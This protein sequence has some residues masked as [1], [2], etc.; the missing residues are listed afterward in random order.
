MYKFL[1]FVQFLFVTSFCY[2]QQIYQITASQAADLAIRNAKDLKNLE[3][4]VEIQKMNNLEVLSAV[5]PQIAASGQATYYTNLPLIQFPTSN[6]AVYQVLEKE[7]VRDGTGNPIDISKASFGVQPV[8]FFAPFNTQLGLNAQQLL[9][10]PDVFIAVTARQT[11]L[12]YAQNNVDVARFKAREQVMKSYYAVLIGKKQQEVLSSS[13]QRLNALLREMKAMYDKGFTEKLDV[14]RIQVSINNTEAALNQLENGLLISESLLKNTM[15]L[16]QKDSLVL[17]ETMDIARLQEVLLMSDTSFDYL[18]RPEVRLLET[19]KKLQDIELNRYRLATL[20]TVSAFYQLQRSGQR[21]E[22]FDINGRGPWFWFTAG[23][24]GLSVNQPIFSGFQRKYKMSQAKLK[25]QKVDNSY[26]QLL[27][28][29]DMERDITKRSFSNAMINVDVQQRNVDLAASVF[30]TTRKKY[31]AGLGSSFEL[32]Q[33]DAD[34]QRANGAY[35]QA[36]YEAHTARI[37]YLKSLGKL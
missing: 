12:D 15:G 36:L 17:T 16:Q 30:E 19:V 1:I 22:N 5:Y 6:I 37:S 25:I 24:V 8:S 26:S 29:I 18:N 2:S 4:D 23:L 13:L 31:Q 9:F 27:S 34:L 28:A 11:V 7:G 21:N 20:P 10:Q 14:D 3:L 33:T 32:I 35:Y